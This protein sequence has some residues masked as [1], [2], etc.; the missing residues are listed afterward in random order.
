LTHSAD[1]LL[2]EIK[3]YCSGDIRISE[4]D[5]LALHLFGASGFEISIRSRFLSL[6]LSIES[7][8][9]PAKRSTS[10]I[11]IVENTI[12]IVKSRNDLSC[13]ER[14]SLQGSLNWLKNES[15]SLTGKKLAHSLLPDNT[16]CE[17]PCEKFFKHC[18]QVRSNLVHTGSP[19]IDEDQFGKV[20]ANLEVFV[21]DM[22][23]A[24]FKDYGYGDKDA[25]R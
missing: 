18:Y 10:A 15:I 7:M 11:E 17:M 1:K 8:L 19:K 2:G 4:R 12:A 25:N 14:D 13:Q 5:L 24:K 9:E 6:M 20:A 3:R 16:Y 21:S 23:T 22:L